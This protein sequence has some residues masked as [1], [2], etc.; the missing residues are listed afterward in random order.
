MSPG[1]LERTIGEI[2]YWHRRRCFAMDQRKRTDSSLAWFLKLALG[3]NKVLPKAEREAVEARVAGLIAAG[4]ASVEAGRLAERETLSKREA[5]S[6]AKAEQKAACDDSAFAEWRD[7]I[8]GS[9]VARAP[10]DAV[11]SQATAEMERLAETLPVWPWF[12]ANVFKDGSRSLA[13][14][15]GEAG[16]LASYP[17]QGH[18]WKRMGLAVIGPGDGTLDTRQGGLLKGAPKAEWVA[19]DYN[20]KRRSTMFVIGDCLVKGKTIYREIYL[21]RKDHERARAEADGLKV[22][23]AAQIPEGRM[24]EFTS[25]GH[26]HKRAQRYMEKRLLR[27]LWRAWRNE[28]QEAKLEVP[29]SALCAL[30]TAAHRIDREAY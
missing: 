3:W 25:D 13:V 4:E 12:S 27:D 29:S 20:A 23:P 21:R 30:P 14:I 28:Q 1:D 5:R 8:E 7:L 9:V 10:F 16:D 15:V 17:K 22:V 6:L 26:V 19:H 24:H 11:E 2:R 18:L